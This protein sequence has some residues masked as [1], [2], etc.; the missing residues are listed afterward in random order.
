MRFDDEPFIPTFLFF[1]V[2]HKGRSFIG[3]DVSDGKVVEVVGKFAFHFGE[4]L[5]H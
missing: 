4:V 3:Q 5:E 1:A 2:V